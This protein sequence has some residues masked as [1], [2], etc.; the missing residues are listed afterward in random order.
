MIIT[1]SVS[2]SS[3]V[4]CNQRFSSCKSI[5]VVGFVKLS[6]DCFC[7]DWVFKM[8]IEFCCH[9]LM[10]FRQSSSMYCDPL[11]LV[12]AFGHSSSQ[13]MMSSRDLFMPSPTWRTAAL[14][15][16]D[17]V[18]VRLQMLRPNAHQQS[19]LLKYMTV[20]PF[21]STFIRTVMKLPVMH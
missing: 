21:W 6:S 18:A 4:F 10:V 7:A 1:P 9:V 3:V 14:D 11:N 8:N 16:A 2:R 13:L 17:Q 15:T 5:V 20:L 19:A 12:L